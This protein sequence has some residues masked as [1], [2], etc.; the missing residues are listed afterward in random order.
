[1]EDAAFTRDRLNEARKKLAER[2]ENLKALE[3][4]RRLQAEHERISAERD[5]LAEEMDRMVEPIVQIAQL[6]RQIDHC[7]RNIGRVNA[8]AASKF[9]LPLCGDGVP[10]G[11]LA[12][13]PAEAYGVKPP[14]TLYPMP[15]I[16]INRRHRFS[17]G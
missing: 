1:M 4:D 15:P 9:G 17:L 7:D 5:R 13:S 12:L 3:K 2:V 14:L 6:V 10:K 16:F 8:L 11:R